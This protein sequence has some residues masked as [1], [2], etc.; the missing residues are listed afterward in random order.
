[1][2]RKESKEW[3]FVLVE[4]DLETVVRGKVEL[5]FFS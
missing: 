5:N 2:E 3:D 1:M 4:I